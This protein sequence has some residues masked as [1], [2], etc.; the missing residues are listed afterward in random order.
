M[1][2]ENVQVYT[3]EFCPNCDL[4][5]AYLKERGVRFTEEDMSSAGALTELRINGV[6]VSEAPV[7]RKGNV[8]LT[9]TELFLGGAVNRD[10]V[11]SLL[12]GA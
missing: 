12:A 3:L 11:D 4:L 7:L 5:K 2:I 10:A 9:S 1:P 8:F 6:F